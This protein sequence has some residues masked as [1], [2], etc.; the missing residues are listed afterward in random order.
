MIVRKLL[1][2]EWSYNDKTVTLKDCKTGATFL[3]PLAYLDSFLRA[4]LAFKN[5]YRKE[6]FYKIQLRLQ[7]QLEKKLRYIK[8]EKIRL[9]K[10]DEHII[11]LKERIDKLLARN[12]KKI[13]K[14]IPPSKKSGTPIPFSE[15]SDFNKTV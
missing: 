15:Q 5:E 7:T 13:I 1:R 4:G 10:K 2:F 9:Q 3:F 14:P 12:K 8:Y 6:Q 11:K